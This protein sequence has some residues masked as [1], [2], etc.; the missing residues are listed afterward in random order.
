MD[1]VSTLKEEPSFVN[2]LLRATERLKEH[3]I[4]GYTINEE[5]IR[6]LEG[7]LSQLEQTI[8]LIHQ[9]SQSDQINLSEA[10]GLLNIISNYTRSFILLNQFDSNRLE[11]EKLNENIS[12]EISYKEAINAIERLKK[13]LIDKKE[14]STLF[15]NQKD[16]SFSG[17]LGNV[18]QSFG[19]EY[20]YS[21]IE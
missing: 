21:S 9:S 19:G 20:V 13:I 10:K 2:G 14:A 11:L 15:G 1:I 18:V 5:R 8:K 4:R 6:Q 7:G 3:L 16:E 17:I 12:Y